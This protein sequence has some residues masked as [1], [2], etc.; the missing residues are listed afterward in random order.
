MNDRPR[1]GNRIRVAGLRIEIWFNENWKGLKVFIASGLLMFLVM[2]VVLY[3]RIRDLGWAVGAALVCAVAGCVIVR[4]VMI[5]SPA[6][7]LA[8]QNEYFRGRIEQ[9]EETSRVDPRRPRR[10]STLQLILLTALGLGGLSAA[11]AL[12]LLFSWG[13]EARYPV[14]AVVVVLSIAW[15]RR[16]HRNVTNAEDGEPS[17]R[18][19]HDLPPRSQRR[20]V[21]P[22]DQ[23]GDRMP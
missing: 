2:A 1:T 13:A 12:P 19:H 8:S 9:L 20:N 4:A 16:L 6:E 14:L 21:S 11:V 5:G 18:A 3:V 22:P 23:S 15:R 7:R 17:L 10:P